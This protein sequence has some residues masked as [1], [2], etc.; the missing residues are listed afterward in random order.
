MPEPVGESGELTPAEQAQLEEFRRAD[1]LDALRYGMA[2]FIP[3]VRSAIDAARRAEE[4]ELSRRRH[5]GLTLDRI[6]EALEQVDAESRLPR[7]DR[8][9]TTIFIDGAPTLELNSPILTRPQDW[10][11]VARR[12]LF[13]E[14][15]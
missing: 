12:Y 4:A 8:R 2:A 9:G 1:Q 15:A 13:G 6:D 10:G 5:D 7:V 11:P 3:G 14:R